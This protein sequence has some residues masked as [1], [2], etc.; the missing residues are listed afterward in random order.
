M[1]SEMSCY[2]IGHSTGTVDKFIQLLKKYNI[3][4][5][6]D[7]RSIPYSK[8]A[9][10][11]NAETLKLELKKNGIIYG[12]MGK[13]LGA[14]YDDPRLLFEDGRV[15]FNKVRKTEFFKHGIDR[16]IHGIKNGYEIAIMCTEKDPFECH[17]FGLVS[18]ELSRK[19][20]MVYHILED[21]SLIN[22]KQLEE[23]LMLKYRPYYNQITLMEPEKT[24]EEY[25]EECYVEHNKQIG[26]INEEG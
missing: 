11:F 19:G 3:K 8:H 26:Y 1:Q 16:I 9:P 15:D 10:Q 22:N 20:V 24:N 13:E 12:Y 25:I 4:Y 21:G 23:K 14:R 5:L 2:S 6:I 7:V 18:H 17:R